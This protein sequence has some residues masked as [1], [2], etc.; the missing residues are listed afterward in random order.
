MGRLLFVVEPKL[1]R[2]ENASKIGMEVDGS[3][4]HE[5]VMYYKLDPIK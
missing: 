4:P 2:G 1:R 5:E 3:N